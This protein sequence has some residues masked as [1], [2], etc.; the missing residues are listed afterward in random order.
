MK[1]GLDVAQTCVE[2][3]GCAWYA[4]ALSRALIEVGLPRGHTFELYHHFGDWINHDPRGGTVVEDAR[5]ARPLYGMNPPAARKFWA[6][7]E[8]GEP[9]PGKPEVVL[10]F[11]FHA[12][13]MP[14]TRLVYTV[15]DLAFWMR[16]DCATDA[17]RL[18]CQREMLQ[19]VA[20]AA[21]FLFISEATRREFNLLL[22]GVLESRP[23]TLTP[24]ASRFPAAPEPRTWSPTAPWLIVG[25]VEPRKNH[26]TALDAYERYFAQSEQPRPLVIIGGA[27]WHS[28]AT[29]RR[30]AA[31]ADRGLPVRYLGYLPDRELAAWYA[32]SFALLAPSWHEGFGL[33]VI[34]AL[35]A[36]LPVIASDRTSLPE[37]G[38]TAGI[39]AS[40]D[41]PAA[42]AIHMLAL[43]RDPANYAGVAAR[44]L[45]RSHDFSWAATA[46]STL[47]FL[48]KL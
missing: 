36:G 17:T 20:R 28:E 26:A 10:S 40:P 1:I 43:E 6:G 21:G 31:M 32:R 34:E 9:L 25:S 3:A 22:P 15:Y 13:K 42:W 16:P 24:G 18:L 44:G 48:E 35:G 29:H 41:D 4:D 37:V 33:P 23:H 12:P 45:A 7:I 46:R 5:V 38:G 27:G 14:H 39:Y 47:E 11:S 30:F 19:A 8:S 2:R